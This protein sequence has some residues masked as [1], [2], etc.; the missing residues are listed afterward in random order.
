MKRILP[1]V[2]ALVLTGVAFGSALAINA[3]IGVALS[4][5]EGTTLTAVEPSTEAEPAAH[6]VK[7]E[8]PE[9]PAQTTNAKAQ[10]TEDIQAV[11]KRNI[12]DS[13]AIGAEVDIGGPPPVTDLNVKLVATLV[14]EPE[15]YSSALIVDNGGSGTA[16]GYSIGDSLGD[17]KVVSIEV[18]RVG[19]QR[20]D[21]SVEY[22]SMDDTTV[23][24]GPRDEGP[25]TPV[26]GSE[27]I[28]K[29]SD[30]KFQVDRSLIDKYLSNID[31]LSGMARATPHNGP[32][33]EPDGFRLGGIRRNS[34]LSQLGMRN[35]DVI[36]MVNG[37]AL[38]N[39]GDAMTAFQ[40]L[41]SQSSFTFEITRRGQK[42]T[43][44]Y[45]I[46]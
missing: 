5:P 21:G 6:P 43:M 2:V 35:G 40:G 13:S 10:L 41:Q 46:R 36:H 24:A 8:R 14:A 22:L 37:Q 44:E 29:I 18:K 34:P 26:E 33:G 9:R 20:A 7:D 17:A 15:S 25:A 23:A 4:L 16:I 30:T 45:E 11:L 1:L 32:D 27:G 39:M 3:A 38:S 19:L 31:E 42:Q 12:F 28:S